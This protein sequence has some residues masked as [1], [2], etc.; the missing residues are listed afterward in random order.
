MDYF[1]QQFSANP[2]KP[3]CVRH[4]ILDQSQTVREM[5]DRVK[6]HRQECGIYGTVQRQG[7]AE[8]KAA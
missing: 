7:L 1:F 4:T 5:V 6:A 2:A 8:W 3:F